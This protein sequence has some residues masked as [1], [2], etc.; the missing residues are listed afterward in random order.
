MNRLA[1]ALLLAL[2]APGLAPPAFAEVAIRTEPPRGYGWWLGDRLTHVVTLAPPPGYTLDPASLP[3][4]RAVEYWLDLTDARTEK[5]TLDGRPAIRITTE[6][7]NFYAPMEPSRRD[8][9]PWQARFLGP[10]APEVVEVPGFSF[11]TSP[12]RPIVA[13]NDA[14]E[15]RPDEGIAPLPVARLARETAG[16][17]LLALLALGGLA[18][19]QGWWPFHARPERPLTRAL[20]RLRRAPDLRARVLALHRGLDAAHGAPLLAADLAGFLAAHPEFAP[21]APEIESFFARSARLFF[22]DGGAEADGDPL[23]LARRLAAIER[24][25][26]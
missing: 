12:I 7:Q 20:A 6:W 23:P 5:T 13:K 15:L 24:G 18:F 26:A 22:G 10:G 8:V 14:S 11:V 1:L 17:G 9:P 4:P 2:A 16:F 25:R 21:L 19:H 3:R